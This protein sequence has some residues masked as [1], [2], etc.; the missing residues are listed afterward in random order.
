MRAELFL[1]ALSNSA[2]TSD[3]IG[4]LV[5]TIVSI[6]NY[7]FRLSGPILE[8]IYDWGSYQVIYNEGSRDNKKEDPLSST[9]QNDP[10][11]YYKEVSWSSL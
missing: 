1:G 10:V 9:T 5:P 4:N 2:L 8:V 7:I 6:S 3:Y 11:G